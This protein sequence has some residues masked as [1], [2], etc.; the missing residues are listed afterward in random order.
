[1]SLLVGYSAVITPLLPVC[2]SLAHNHKIG[3]Q[4]LPPVSMV[5]YVAIILKKQAWSDLRLGMTT[6]ISALAQE[7]REEAPDIWAIPQVW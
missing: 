2:R 1:M 5:V 6:V 4:M 7:E 3:P